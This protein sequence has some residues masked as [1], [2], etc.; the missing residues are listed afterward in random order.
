MHICIDAGKSQCVSPSNIQL[1]VWYKSIPRLIAQGIGA[2]RYR[3]GGVLVVEEGDGKGS[4]RGATFAGE[5]TTDYKRLLFDLTCPLH[6][7]YVDTNR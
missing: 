3:L 7:S 4:L 6:L 2:G 5:W 1:S